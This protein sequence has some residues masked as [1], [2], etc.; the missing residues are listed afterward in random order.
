MKTLQSI[1]Q[2]FVRLTGG[3]A[4]EQ[5]APSAQ[6]AQ[7]GNVFES[8][9]RIEKLMGLVAVL[10]V[11]VLAT[12]DVLV[13]L[14]APLVREIIRVLGALPLVSWG[15]PMMPLLGLLA[16]AYGYCEWKVLP[17]RSLEGTV[18]FLNTSVTIAT[19]SGSLGTML[20]LAV[21]PDASFSHALRSSLVGVGAALLILIRKQVLPEPTVRLNPPAADSESPHESLQA[22]RG[23]ATVG[24]GRSSDSSVPAA[25]DPEDQDASAEV[26]TEDSF[27]D[28]AF[29]RYSADQDE[30]A[31]QPED[32]S[33]P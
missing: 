30:D 26:N 29:A 16:L 32:G 24:P 25:D 22:T 18:A 15:G 9:S 11:L 1:A 23:G 4:D 14:G 31:A 7:P 21:N 8:A 10:L 13:P 17:A 33:E 6:S 2:F 28:D 3:V 5:H 19:L 20:A 12:R 27:W